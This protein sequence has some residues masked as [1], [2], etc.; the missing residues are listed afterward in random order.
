MKRIILFILLGFGFISCDSFLEVGS[1]TSQLE[2]ELVFKNE[3][4]AIAAL[5]AI[6]HELQTNG[7]ASGNAR[8]TSFLGNVLADDSIE[9][10]V[11]DDRY[12]FY[13]NNLHADNGTNNSLWGSAYKQLYNANALLE[14]IKDNVDLSEETKNRIEGEA[15]F[16]RA[17]IYYYLVH[18]YDEVPLVLI[19]DYHTNQSL[20]RSS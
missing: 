20:A 18:L 11:S 12:D 5:E 10:N 19:T 9:Y 8:S 7:F 6:F 3:N 13:T 2:A 1:N 15:K 17:F 4:T 14:G 16:L